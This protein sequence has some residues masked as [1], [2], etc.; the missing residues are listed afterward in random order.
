MT[1]PAQW[2]ELKGL[3]FPV[4]KRA[5]GGSTLIDSAASGR[6]V[7]IG[8]WSLP[9]WEWDLTYGYLP[10]KQANGTTANDLKTQSGYVLSHFGALRGFP[11]R[12]PSH[13]SV[14]DQP[15][16]TGDGVA[17]TFLLIATYGL[18]PFTVN[19]PIGYLMDSPALVL[20]KNG[21]VLSEG[22]D[23][24]V[25]TDQ[26][27]TQYVVLTTPPA[28]GD[29]LTATMEFC[30]MVRI[31]EDTVE[32]QEMFDQLWECQKVTLVSLRGT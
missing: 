16:G 11:Y 28:P 21:T 17:D 8:L 24:S 5:I 14:T 19:E 4:V 6:E 32:Y 15:I 9:K 3:A 25:N 26:P 31:K 7:R 10:D 18:T 30:Y 23:Y 12:D 1:M 20:K 29:L 13:Y 22:P 2:P 27:Y